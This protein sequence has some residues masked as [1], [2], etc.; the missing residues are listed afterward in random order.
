MKQT[1]LIL[2]IFLVL[3]SCTSSKNIPENQ[4]SISTTET[5][6]RDGSSFEK[7][8][9]ITEKTES[10]GIHAEY[11]WL[12]IH[13]PGYKRGIQ[14]LAD[15]KKKP[16]DIITIKTSEGKNPDVYFDI[17]NFYGKF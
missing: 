11:E 4:S 3:H 6:I 14:A 8:I 10:K 9:I 15:H 2:I 5:K 12:Q 13:Y 16:Y 1:G 7:A 17:S